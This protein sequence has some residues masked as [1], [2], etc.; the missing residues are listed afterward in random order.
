MGL[1][2]VFGVAGNSRLSGRVILSLPS[3]H[4]IHLGDLMVMVIGSVGLLAVTALWRGRRHP[5]PTQPRTDR[6]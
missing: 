6:H 3:S 4:G 1:L 5:S 2:M